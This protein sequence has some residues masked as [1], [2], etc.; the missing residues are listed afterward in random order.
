[1]ST[2]FVVMQSDSDSIMVCTPMHRT[3]TAQ[4]ISFIGSGPVNSWNRQAYLTLDPRTGTSRTSVNEVTDNVIQ[5]NFIMAGTGTST[6]PIDHDDCSA[7]YHDHHNVLLF[8]PAK[9]WGGHSKRATNNL[10][11]WPDYGAGEYGRAACYDY[12]ATGAYN[13]VFANN[14]CILSGHRQTPWCN[15]TGCGVM[16][17]RDVCPSA[18]VNLSVAAS[19]LVASNNTYYTPAGAASWRTS[20]QGCALPLRYV[21]EREEEAGSRALDVSQLST[22]AILARIKELLW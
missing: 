22:T 14:T 19:G 12:Q 9:Q 8:G 16:T 10:Q 7:S 17:F 18:S 3:L 4:N 6:Y 20:D 11:I 13:E 15:H 2:L 5:R 21:Q 1:M